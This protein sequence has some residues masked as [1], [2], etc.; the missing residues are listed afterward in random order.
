M[1][2]RAMRWAVLSALAAMTAAFVYVV[3]RRL[4]Y[5]H[6]LEWMTGAI[7]DHVDRFRQGQPIYTQP[8]EWSAYIYPPGYYWAVAALSRAIPDFLAGRLISLLATFIQAGCI[9]RLARRHGA[10][11][12]WALVG[13]GLLFAAFGFTG[14][15]YDLDRCDPLFL[16]M[17]SVGAVIL[18]ERDGLIATAAAGFL[19][20]ASFFVKQPA[21]M[22]L[23]WA[24]LGLLLRREWK[25]AAL[26]AGVSGAVLLVGVAWLHV[27]SKGW[28]TYFVIHIP[29]GHGFERELVKPFFIDDV[30]RAF[31]LS[32]ITAAVAITLLRD[33][34][35]DTLF[36][37]FLLAGLV[38][39][40]TS[41]LHLGGWPNVLTFWTTFAC[42]GVAVVGTR[43]EQCIA[44]TPLEHPAMLVCLSV[45]LLQVGRWSYWPADV[46]PTEQ[47][48]QYAAA[49]EQKIE[50]ME[51][52][53]E[54]V[55][56]VGR[57]HLTHPRR[58]HIGGMI[59]ALQ[60]DP[61]VPDTVAELFR[62]QRFSA[63]IV[64]AI[65][66]LSMPEVAHLDGQ[67]L[68][69]VLA[70]YYFAERL[71]EHVGCPVVGWI[72]HPRWLL[73]PRV[74]TLDT[75]N[76]KLLDD[77]VAMEMHLSELLWRTQARPG[78]LPTV[79]QLA[80]HLRLKPYPPLLPAHVRTN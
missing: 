80:D 76:R 2:V 64:D 39:S 48:G 38:A 36:S 75:S 29:G 34:R 42:A 35:R 25:R 56:V 78:A 62:S 6:E 9:Y 43:F 32:F 23:A 71:D 60:A 72:T 24:T 46:I 33:R 13:A 68:K 1:I 47:N 31:L 27:A 53:G 57:S 59:A 19:L 21:T 10:T 4:T 45:V 67:F 40:C 74:A 77:R 69:I 49:F 51:R 66:D 16:A 41:R 17:V 73:R 37:C 30:S 20:G 11:R 5:P 55:L 18:T 63:I 61:H 79:E 8:G 12:Y 54:T 22:F 65:E 70:H 14:F 58:F 3:A 15:W 52:D 50:A 44:H 26:F 7:L 28:F